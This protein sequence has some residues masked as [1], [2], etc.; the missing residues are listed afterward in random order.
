MRDL[1]SEAGANELGNEKNAQSV[2]LFAVCFEPFF[3]SSRKQRF[4]KTVKQRS[5]R[6]FVLLRKCR[7]LASNRPDQIIMR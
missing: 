2:F 7:A 4:W 5:E 1:I 6:F 3:D